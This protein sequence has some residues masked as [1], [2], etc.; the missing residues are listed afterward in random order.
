MGVDTHPPL[1][2]R[3]PK[4]SSLK[5]DMQQGSVARKPVADSIQAELTQPGGKKGKGDGV[6][7]L[8]KVMG[9]R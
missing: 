5:A 2:G 8:G 7:K 6:P 1:K 3:E 4:Y 9:N